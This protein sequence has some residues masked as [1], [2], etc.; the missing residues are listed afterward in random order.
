M[1]P[2]FVYFCA[3]CNKNQEAFRS[4]SGRDKGPAC[5]ECGHTMKRVEF[6]KETPAGPNHRIPVPDP[7][8]KV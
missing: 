3:R 6:P 1:S 5:R 4:V 7:F 8:R 2:I